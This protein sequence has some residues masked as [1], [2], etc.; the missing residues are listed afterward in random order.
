MISIYYLLFFF[1]LALAGPFLLLSKKATRAGVFQKF[2]ILPEDLKT[3]IKAIPESQARIWFHAVSVGEFNALYPL[4]EEFSKRHPDYKIFISTTTATGQEL[5]KKRAGDIAEVFYFPFDLPFSLNCFLDLIRPDTVGIVETEIWPGFMHE[6]HKRKINVVLLNGRLS[7]RSLK[8]YSR[9]R[10]FFQPVLAQFRALAVQSQAEKSRYLSLAGKNLRIEVCGNIKLDGLKACS[11]SETEALRRELK[12]DKSELT[13]VAGSTHEGEETAF[14]KALKELNN[15]FRLILVP[16]HPERFERAAEL[17]E[18][19]GFRVRRF[20]RNEAFESE[21][22]I[23]L[24]DTIGQLNKFYSLADIAF[25]GGT[26]ANIGGHNLA[27]PCA[28]RTP[29]LCGPHTHKARDLEQKL[30][31]AEALLQLND[32]K[33]LSSTLKSLLDSPEKRERLGENGYRFLSANQ[34]ALV[35]TLDLL[36]EY[37]GSKEREIEVEVAGRRL[38]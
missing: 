1:A 10:C 5:A 7:P 36:E 22:D 8:G 13:L 33:D 17:I 21:K 30:T 38:R 31:E 34:G 19:H 12:I 29:V 24:L 14:I 18:M 27:E 2:G 25:V 6:C 32:E 16:R 15:S 11:Q 28:Y 26:L 37:L 3:R 20:S 4:A 35:K 23:Y 9:W